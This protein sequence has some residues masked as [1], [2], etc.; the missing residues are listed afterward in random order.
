MAQ[1]ELQN[2]LPRFNSGRGLQL[3]A[4]A[5]VSAWRPSPE[6]PLRHRAEGEAWRSGW[7]SGDGQALPFRCF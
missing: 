7:A 2:R 1:V 6:G 4:A 3:F 5:Q